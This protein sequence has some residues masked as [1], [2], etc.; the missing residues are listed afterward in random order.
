MEQ[1]QPH[2]TT[3]EPGALLL[4]ARDDRVTPE[5]KLDKNK[6]YKSPIK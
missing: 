5:A 3:G 6:T 1:T 4:S 2:A